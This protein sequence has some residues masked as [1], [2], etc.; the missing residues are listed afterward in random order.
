MT[1][2]HEVDLALSV[3]RFAA[4]RDALAPLPNGPARWV[5]EARLALELC[6][7]N[8]LE[9]MRRAELAAH[10]LGEGDPDRARAIEVAL[11]AALRC[12]AAQTAESYM[13]RL[14]ALRPDASRT[15]AYRG[16]VALTFDERERA[17]ALLEAAQREDPNCTL[18]RNWLAELEYIQGRFAEARSLLAPFLETAT[19]DDQT[20]AALRLIGHCHAALGAHLEEA[21]VRRILLERFPD[22]A[23]AGSDRLDLAFALA[24]SG[25]YAETIQELHTL[26][27][28]EPES[29]LGRY[30]RRRLDHLE[31]GASDAGPAKRLEQFPTTHQK[32]NF[33]GPAVLELCLR[34]LGIEL[35]QDEIA[36]VVKRETGTPMYEISAFLAARGI[37]A[38]R[39][40]ATPERMRA[41]IDLGLPVIVQEEYST[42]SH[43]AVVTGYDTRLGAFIAQDPMTHRPALKAY[44]WAENAGYLFGNG[45][46]VVIGRQEAVSEERLLELDRAGLIEEPHFATLDDADRK[47]ASASAESEEALV[48]EVLEA[49]QLALAQEPYY[50]LAWARRTWASFSRLRMHDIARTR[51]EFLDTLQRARTTFPG[52]EWA[53]RV[54]GA[55]LEYRGR[56]REAYVEYLQAHRADPGDATNLDD[57]ADALRRLGDF[58]EAERRFTEALECVPTHLGAAENL[59]ALY[60]AAL[61]GAKPGRWLDTDAT[62]WA[63]APES[64]AVKTPLVHDEAELWARAEWYAALALREDPSKPYN[65]VQ[66]GLLAAL[67][68]EFR[69]AREQFARAAEHNDGPWIRSREA[70]AAWL[71]EDFADVERIAALLREHFPTSTEAWLWTAELARQRSDFDAAFEALCEGV[72]RVGGERK[73]LVSAL[74]EAGKHFG[75][76]E[77]AAVRL[78]EIVHEAPHDPGFVR[79]VADQVDYEGQRGIAIELLRATLELEPGDINVRYRLGALLS[80]DNTTHEEAQALLAEV[81]RQA[82]NQALPHQ[83]LAWTYLESDPAQGFQTVEPFIEEGAP[84]VLETAG[85]LASAMGDTDKGTE[86]RTRAL[87]AYAT[88]AEG[89]VALARYH[90]QR[91][92]Y[93]LAAELVLPI[94]D[95]APGV[96]SEELERVVLTSAR[97]S[98]RQMGVLPWVQK[99]CT[100]SVPEH[101]AWETY[102]SYR[103]ADPELAARAADVCAKTDDDRESQL[104]YRIS[105]A[106]C[107]ARLGNF[108]PLDA[109]ARDVGENGTAWA[110]L[111]FAYDGAKR[112]DRAQ[113][114]AERAHALSPFDLYCLSAWESF[115]IDQGDK[116]GAIEAARTALERH[117]YQHL[118]DER[119]ALLYGRDLDVERALAH[120]QRALRLAPFCHLAQASRAVALFMAGDVERAHGHAQRSVTL[121]TS[122]TPDEWGDAEAI[123]RALRGD[124]D[125]LERLFEDRAVHRKNWPFTAYDA[126]LR[127]TAQRAS[128]T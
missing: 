1:E 102:W 17:R 101:L 72:R 125:G 40:A 7:G 73:E 111:Y 51:G 27:K 52:A 71:A 119:L 115:C 84:Q 89:R 54:H 24:A 96:D 76:K 63:S 104:E 13:E 70:R 32:R 95:G 79:A 67:K 44:E 106:A 58:A 61:A 116:Q 59:A 64:E 75:G 62:Q 66:C 56:L 57:M 88:E 117:P 37:I 78:R 109:I 112:F 74:W 55:Y 49:C 124:S 123:V 105:A 107:R 103:H 91:D 35:G 87:H 80:E 22:G 43:V 92:R 16:R 2:L 14:E 12:R 126:K 114:A 18:S 69:A 36:G 38:R 113:E 33:C 108:E 29:G 46:V 60:V 86:L 128:E 118:G 3:E 45:G 94:R 23:H 47:R 110:H 8:P 93:D 48:D 26:W 53:H 81:V 19:R 83:T 68:G 34:F 122:A 20:A 82:P 50:P 77:A 127:S 97:L 99:R 10:A 121:E 21:R 41:A 85:V 9:A 25:D 100:E 28:S 11:D 120:S 65:L 15:R 90:V 98:G 4:A 30:A 6:E 39:V 31:S 5:R 42:T